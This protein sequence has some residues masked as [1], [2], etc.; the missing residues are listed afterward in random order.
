MPFLQNHGA[1]TAERFLKYDLVQTAKNWGQ[2]E[3][4]PDEWQILPVTPEEGVQARAERAKVVQEYEPPFENENGWAVHALGLTGA[5]SRVTFAQLEENVELERSRLYYNVA[6]NH[7]HVNMKGL[8]DDV[9]ADL[10]PSLRGF[11]AA[12][13]TTLV[14]LAD[15]TTIMVRL[16]PTPDTEELE[17]LLNQAAT[18]A[19]QTFLRIQEQIEQEAQDA[20][21]AGQ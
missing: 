16:R 14:G 5:N 19:I 18:D 13:C 20:A 6:S 4:L 7:I 21:R 15:C 2:Y 10:F 1:E 9:S 12:A 8:A 17:Q 3:R 11:S